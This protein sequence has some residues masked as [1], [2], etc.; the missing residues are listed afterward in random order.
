MGSPYLHYADVAGEVEVPK[1]GI[2]SRTLHSDEQAK[3]VIFGFD[4]GQELSEHTASVPAIL[5]ILSGEA[6]LTLGGDS[7]PAAPGAWAYMPAQLP[8]SIMARS[9]LV[10]LLVMLKGAKRAEG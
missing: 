3:V 9:P 10:M 1:D 7:F 6:D 8:H 2:I 4:T 5:H